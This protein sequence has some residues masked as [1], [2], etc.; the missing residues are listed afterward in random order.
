MESKQKKGKWY[1]S[2]SIISL[3]DQDLFDEP[4]RTFYIIFKTLYFVY[5]LFTILPIN[6]HYSSLL[7]DTLFF[8][9][10]SVSTISKKF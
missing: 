5:L 4:R 3:Y 1:P 7:Y 6:I 10:T 8:L 9:K 2:I